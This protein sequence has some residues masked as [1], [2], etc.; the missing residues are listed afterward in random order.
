[1][2]ALA[3]IAF[4]ASAQVS[5]A[6]QAVAVTVADG[7]PVQILDDLFLG[8]NLDSGS[9]AKNIQLSN[10]VLVQLAR[11]LA[12]A[13]L[14]VGGTS[15]DSL[16]YIPDG[17]AGAGPSPDPL[18]PT[19]PG[20][21]SAFVPNVTIMNN[22][23]WE[24]VVGFASASGLSLLFDLNAV[25]FRT[26]AGDWDPSLNASA[27]LEYTAANGLD[28]PAWELGNEA[29]AWREEKS[30]CRCL[31]FPAWARLASPLSHRLWRTRISF[32][33]SKPFIFSF[34]FPAS[35]TPLSAHSP[36]LSQ[37]DLWTKHLG[38]T[39]T[40]QQLATDLRTLQSA[41]GQNGLS[42]SVSGPS[43][44]TFNSGLLQPYL[45]VRV[46]G[47]VGVWAGRPRR[48]RTRRAPES[49]AWAP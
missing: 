28:V 44:A 20:G 19:P 27:L 30:R 40:G 11:N 9:L 34:Q 15:S 3:F 48:L 36:S 17:E 32:L 21:F 4:F 43:L 6:Q 5:H 1:M 14:R 49:D 24:E 33:I 8:V 46:R 35:Q 7:S 22:Q 41:L 42:T 39:P 2:R 12:P 29:R 31:F 25:D 10:A 16:W 23:A 38:F 18:S 26:S 47:R 37:P 45:Q 13:Q